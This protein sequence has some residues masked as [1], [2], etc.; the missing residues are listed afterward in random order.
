MRA[1]VDRLRSLHEH[2]VILSLETVAVPRVAASRRLDIDELGYKDDGITFV[3]AS[4]GYFEHFDVPAMLRLID[5]AGVECPLE[6]SEASFF[7]SQVELEPTDKPGMNRWRKQL[8]LATSVLAAEPADYFRL[9]RER[10]LVLG[11]QIAF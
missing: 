1:S 3:R 9:P 10:T 2:V 11:S 8:F 4:Y 7:V 5:Q 6:V